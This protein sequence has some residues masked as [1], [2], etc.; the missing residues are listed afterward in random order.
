MQGNEV[1]KGLIIFAFI[2]IS[3]VPETMA[4][5]EGKR[6]AVSS[7]IVNVRS[8]PGIKA[9]ILWQVEKYHPFVIVKT[10]NKWYKVRDFENDL[11]WIHSSLLKSINCVITTKDKCN[12]RSAPTINSKVV[13]TVDKGVPFKQLQKKGK[14][15]KIKHMHGN[16]GWIHKSLV[17]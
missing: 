10:K 1:L 3:A 13:F 15:I 11:G 12:V 4:A 5:S 17:W 9:K 2:L 7:G 8:S 14:W 16:S 6:L